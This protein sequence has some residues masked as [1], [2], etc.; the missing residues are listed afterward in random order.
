MIVH[1]LTNFLILRQ[2]SIPKAKHNSQVCVHPDISKIIQNGTL[3][4][5]ASD[6]QVESNYIPFTFY[7]SLSE[8]LK[9]NI[10]PRQNKRRVKTVILAKGIIKKTYLK[11]YNG[12]TTIVINS[13]S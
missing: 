1:L 11:N 12:L 5:G 4:S 9:I 6:F 8:I 2:V 7:K 3:V 13:D 10:T